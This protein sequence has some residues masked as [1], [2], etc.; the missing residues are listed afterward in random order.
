M[1]LQHLEALFGQETAEVVDVVAHLQSIP[2]S[3]YKVKLLEEGNL[4]VLKRGAIKKGC[5]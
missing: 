3:I 1:L 5:M 2:G 4:Q